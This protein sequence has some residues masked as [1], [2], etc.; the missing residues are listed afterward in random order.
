MPDTDSDRRPTEIRE[1]GVRIMKYL[2]DSEFNDL[3]AVFYKISV[4][5][6]TPVR[7]TF[8]EPIPEN[9]TFEQIHTHKDFNGPSWSK[10]GAELVFHHKIEPD[11]EVTTL[12]AFS[13]PMGEIPEDFINREPTP[14]VE[15]LNPEDAKDTVSE[16]LLAEL[17]NGEADED[18]RRDLAEYFLEDL[19]E[20]AV[21]QSEL[22]TVTNMAVE[23]EEELETLSAELD[24]IRDR[25]ASLKSDHVSVK[26]SVGIVERRLDEVQSGHEAELKNLN[27]NISSV[28]EEMEDVREKTGELPNDV[29]SWLQNV[30]E[31][32][33]AL[34]EALEDAAGEHS[35]FAER[36]EGLD[37]SV[38]A[39]DEDLDSF[40]SDVSN[41]FEGL[42][43]RVDEQEDHLETV[44]NTARTKLETAEE[45]R[46]D[47]EEKL[48]AVRNGIEKLADSHEGLDGD[49]GDIDAI[50]A[51]VVVALNEIESAVGADDGEFIS[52][53]H[54][55]DATSGRFTR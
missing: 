1:R 10:D 12:L 38:D 23:L 22:A 28:Q 21:T 40:Q 34:N 33:D 24:D 53:D 25:V 3:T 44:Q 46:E 11:E 42:R 13:V 36:V 55:E 32:I 31:D 7:L 45:E 47:L 26:E 15:R 30:E 2:D 17:R 41:G 9:L 48:V 20:E 6:D 54:V 19:N 5:T 50:I 16:K 49:V 37:D 35:S 14:E 8:R 39:V 27:R 52:E 29:G 4:H 18:V 51:D 43:D